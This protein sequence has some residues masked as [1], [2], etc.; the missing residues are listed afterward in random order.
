MIAGADRIRGAAAASLLAFRIEVHNTH[1]LSS[2]S[3]C[4]GK[5]GPLYK[6]WPNMYFICEPRRC[7]GSS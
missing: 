1:L 5:K 3:R 7:L 6:H 4:I 2:N